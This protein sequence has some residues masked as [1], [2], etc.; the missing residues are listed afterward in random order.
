[1]KLVLGQWK[2]TDAAAAQNYAA[3]VSWIDE[4]KRQELVKVLQSP[5]PN[6][7]ADDDE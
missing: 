1:M 3:N 2:Q 4:Q 5:P 7:V 6:L